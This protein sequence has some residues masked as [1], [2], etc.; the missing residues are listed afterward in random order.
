MWSVM[1]HRQGECLQQQYAADHQRNAFHIRLDH[2]S[3]DFNIRNCPSNVKL[4]DAACM[5][6]LSY[7]TTFYKG[8]LVKH[9]AMKTYAG[10]EVKLHLSSLRHYWKMIAQLHAP[11]TLPSGHPLDGRLDGPHSRSRRFTITNHIHHHIYNNFKKIVCV[12]VCAGLYTDWQTEY[13]AQDY[14]VFGL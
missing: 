3:M 9:Y 6:L 8:K 12:C 5:H 11:A 14:W 7:T 4:H 1:L 13:D 10:V 2:W